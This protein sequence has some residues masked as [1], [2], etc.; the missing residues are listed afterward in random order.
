[1]LICSKLLDI[2][3]YKS[4]VK[5]NNKI[6]IKIKKYITAF[7]SEIL[8]KFFITYNFFSILSFFAKIKAAKYI[9]KPNI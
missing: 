1:M 7:C 6:K 8:K 2:V 5:I 3:F 4:I 9:A